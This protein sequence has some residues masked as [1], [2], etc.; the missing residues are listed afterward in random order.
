[1]PLYMMC[2]EI[3]MIVPLEKTLGSWFS[4]ICK[5]AVIEITVQESCVL[6]DPWVLVV[7]VQIQTYFVLVTQI[8]IV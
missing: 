2:I 1:M 7:N 4:G 8:E 6:H 5:N 3:S